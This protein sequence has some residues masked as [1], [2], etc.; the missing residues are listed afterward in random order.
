MNKYGKKPKNW[1]WDIV[2]D[3][4]I[5]SEQIDWQSLKIQDML[6]IFIESLNNKSHKGIR[7][8]RYQG[9]YDVTRS[10]TYCINQ[11]LNTIQG[12]EFKKRKRIIIPDFYSISKLEINR[13]YYF[14][15]Y[16]NTNLFKGPQRDDE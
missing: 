7:Y 11:L 12:M 4:Y 9:F 6:K 2:D 15:T 13:G 3:A 14:D 16:F 8:M 5:K 1:H 10:S